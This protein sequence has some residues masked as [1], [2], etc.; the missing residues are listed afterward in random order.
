MPEKNSV[1]INRKIR[2]MITAG[3]PKADII[4]Y[5]LENKDVHLGSVTRGMLFDVYAGLADGT[6]TFPLTVKISEL[7]KLNPS[8]RTRNG[9]DW[10]RVDSSYI[11][12]K[13]DIKLNKEDRRVEEIVVLGPRTT[14][15][16]D[17]RIS[18]DV[19]KALKGGRCAILD[20][21]GNTEIDH[22]NGRYNYPALADQTP[23]DFQNLSKAANDAKRQHCKQCRNSG[24][25]YDARRIGYSA[26]WTKGDEKTQ[27]CEGCY[28]HDPIAFNKAISKN[29]GKVSIEDRTKELWEKATGF[30]NKVIAFI[31]KG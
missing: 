15:A 2:E 24:C 16:I 26:G 30:V 31:R 17:R 11:A 20:T 3:E 4:S 12:K 22:K 23:E 1:A 28:W 19:R 21:G 13:Y 9:C 8:Y 29:F 10:A 5:A 7:E 14:P 6:A 27:S 25:R 18:A